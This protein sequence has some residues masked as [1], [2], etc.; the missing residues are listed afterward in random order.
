VAT[1]EAA[2]HAAGGTVIPK[3]HAAA[4]GV[5]WPMSSVLPPMG[6]LTSAPGT[7]RAHVRAVLAGWG[8]PE[9]TEDCELVLSELTTNAV[10]ASTGPAGRLLYVNGRMPVVRVCLFSDGVRLLIEVWDQAMGF[11]ALRRPASEAEAGR[12]LHLVD[13]LTGGRWGWQPG[14]GPAKVVWARLTS[15]LADPEHDKVLTGLGNRP[16][17]DGERPAGG[18]RGATSSRN[19]RLHVRWGR[20]GEA[21]GELRLV[22][23]VEDLRLAQ[24]FSPAVMAPLQAEL[25][26]DPE[27][28]AAA[29]AH[30]DRVLGVVGGGV[31]V[32]GVGVGGEVIAE[33]A[34]VHHRGEDAGLV[35]GQPVQPVG[36]LLAVEA[37]QSR[38]A[39]VVTTVRVFIEAVG[40]MR[41]PTVV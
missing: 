17:G 6:A 30:R 25:E 20:A 12:G 37:A 2:P 15:E 28:R 18:R 22:A 29:G 41:E 3:G 1:D 4:P 32:G 36:E 11:P 14:H 26:E 38:L 23:R 39:R 31:W 21:P 40:G 27:L 33:L 19:L 24:G 8:L 16:V 35:P 5:A 9:L 34:V 10:E 13:A 7:A